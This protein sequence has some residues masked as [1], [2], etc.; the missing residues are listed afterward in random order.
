LSII[1]RKTIEWYKE[2]DGPEDNSLIDTNQSGYVYQ[3]DTVGLERLE[4]WRDSICWEEVQ[5]NWLAEQG[6]RRARR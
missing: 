3:K 4:D 1:S 2:V 5:A 6:D